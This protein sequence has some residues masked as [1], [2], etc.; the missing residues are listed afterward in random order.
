[1]LPEVELIPAL[2]PGQL[3]QDEQ[4]ADQVGDGGGDGGPGHAQGDDRHKQQVQRDVQQAA[5]DQVVQGAAGVAH[6]PQD[7]RAHVE[8]QH[9]DGA[10]EVQAQVGGGVPH[11]LLGVLGPPQGVGGQE[12]ADDRYQRARRQAEGDGGVDGPGELGLVVRPV[13]VGDDHRGPGGQAG[14]D[15]HHQLHDHGSRAAHGGQGVRTHELAHD[16]GINGAVEL[17]EQG[18]GSD[19]E[20]EEKQLFPDDTFGQIQIGL[21]V[22]QGKDLLSARRRR[23]GNA[24]TEAAIC[25]RMNTTIIE[26]TPGKSNHARGRTHPEKEGVLYAHSHLPDPAAAAADL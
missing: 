25:D 22:G 23:D 21:G 24:S 11:D 20:Q 6:G 18:P 3:Q 9:G 16:D 12:D 19:G 26:E 2:G 7:A 8:Q 1:M 4:G 13:A 14:E 17:L 10:E 5:D 15:A